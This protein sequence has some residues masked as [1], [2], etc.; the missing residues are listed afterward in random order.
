MSKERAMFFFLIILP[1][2]FI[3]MFSTI[4]GNQ[5]YT[6]QVHYIDQDHTTLSKDFINHFS[7]S[8][9]FKVVKESDEKEVLA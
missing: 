2:L 4:L 7:P 3:V 8:K 9:T 1:I 5:N 6:F